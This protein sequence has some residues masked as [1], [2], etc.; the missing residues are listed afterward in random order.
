MEFS[1]L[2]WP[3]VI[4]RCTCFAMRTRGRM[5]VPRREVAAG[6]GGTAQPF[7]MIVPTAQP[8]FMIVGIKKRHKKKGG[9][10]S[11]AS[12]HSH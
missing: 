2:D 12:P 8:S 9:G 5:G 10:L 4:P 7:S 6:T 11:A 3:K 1:K